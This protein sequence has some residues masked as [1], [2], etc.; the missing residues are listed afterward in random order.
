MNDTAADRRRSGT[1]A[2]ALW[3]P[4]F[5]HM[6]EELDGAPA[7]VA[8]YSRHFLPEARSDP[9]QPP[10]T[11]SRTR[12][13]SARALLALLTLASIA[14]ANAPAFADEP[15]RPGAVIYDALIER[16]I[17]LVE[18]VVG[19]GVATVAY[20][21][22]LASHNSEAVVDRCI[23]DP[24]R[25][26]FARPLGRFSKRPASLC[27]PVGLSWGL[28][29]MSFSLVER[30]LGLLFGGSPLGDDEGAPPEEL[31]IDGEPMD[32]PPPAELAI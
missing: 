21:V 30:P 13:A 7:G 17:G 18:T 31:E 1:P 20:P 9:M 15:L 8:A 29:G 12:H 16:P 27:S 5:A 6:P 26:T 24:A 3:F 23:A 2:K 28:V 19:L 4:A 25:Y 14:L 22:G 32:F 10:R 11:P